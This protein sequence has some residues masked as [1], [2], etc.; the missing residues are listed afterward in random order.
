MGL[1]LT[2]FL[3]N[4]K[5]VRFMNRI[6]LILA[7][8]CLYL[9]TGCG[10]STPVVATY[11][12]EQVTLR[13]FEEQFAK[14][15]G[16]WEN[17]EKS[18]AAERKAF[19][20][21][22]LKFRL[23]VAEAK[24][25][26]LQADTAIVSELQAYRTT[27]AQSYAVEKEIIE[28]RLKELYERKKMDL[29]CSHIL[30]EIRKDS[31][32]NSDTL[33]AYTKAVQIIK[34]AEAGA[35][36]DSLADA[37]S[38]DPSAMM[39]GGDLGYFSTGR[40]VPEFEDACYALPINGIAHYPVR[41]QFGYHVIKLTGRQPS[42]GAVDL[43]HI[44]FRAEGADTAGNL[45]DTAN[46]VYRQIMNGT[47]TFEQAVLS[48]SKDKG[49]VAAKGRVG[50]FERNRLPVEISNV[51]FQ[52]E[53][54][55]VSIPV[56]SRMGI[57]LFRANAFNGIGSYEENVREM[58]QAYQQQRFETDYTQFLAHLR[59]Q[60]RL[61]YDLTNLYQFERAFDSSLTARDSAWKR[62]IPAE[63]RTRRIYSVGAITRTVQDIVN[64]IES[65][66]E[67]RLSLLT[68]SNVET[69]IK[70]IADADLLEEHAKTAPQRHPAL[71][72]L[73]DEYRDG[74]LMYRIEQDEVWKKVFVNDSVLKL[75]YDTTGYR[76]RWPDRVSF[77]EIFVTTD[78]LAWAAYRKLQSGESFLAVADQYT[79][80][81]GYKE[82]HG[83]WELMPVDKSPLS[84]K[85]SSMTLDSVS[86]PFKNENGWSIL[87]TLV[88]DAARQKTFEEATAELSSSYQDAASKRREVEWISTLKKKFAVT[89]NE[90]TLAEA[91][92]GARREAK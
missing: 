6:V 70:R 33:S 74:V 34:L 86:A 11:G 46:T 76:Y 45:L 17:G 52:L 56:Q 79:M 18:T 20:D 28:P 71:A 65:G 48:Y 2:F 1:L 83:L 89:V 26:G 49:T 38:E 42:K 41:T 15:N 75:H 90:T 14:N 59:A 54:D 39:N 13:E 61:E 82:R 63:W 72:K 85:A 9:L 77:A 7:G 92:K 87:K 24:A 21:L 22:L 37:F 67:F 57:H 62:A 5:N 10:S 30:L 47:L 78:S 58:K 27:V 53:K 64:R 80:R 55:S 91:F 60:Y 44:L 36:F 88:Y 43:S 73:M 50:V 51:V 19:L 29:R 69:M 40:M 23:K 12:S 81:P 8:C 16:G 25:L 35:P 4:R 84:Q 68:P 32:G 31:T 3:S 66:E